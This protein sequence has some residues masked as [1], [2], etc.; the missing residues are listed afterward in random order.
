VVGQSVTFFGAWVRAGEEIGSRS[1]RGTFDGV[2]FDGEA[3][4]ASSSLLI[5]VPLVVLLS[6]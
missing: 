6:T 1:N 4:G 5:R 3:F 2:D